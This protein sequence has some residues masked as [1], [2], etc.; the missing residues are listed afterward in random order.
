MTV[1][2]LEM[3][4][5]ICYHAQENI[6]DPYFHSTEFCDRESAFLATSYVVACLLAQNTVNGYGGVESE[7]VLNQLIDITENEDGLMLKSLEEWEDIIKINVE[8]FGGFKK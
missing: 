8:S 5:R 6:C 7:I 4:A 2:L 1:D 3:L